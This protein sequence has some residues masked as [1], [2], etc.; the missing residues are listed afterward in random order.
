MLQT[1]NV[2]TQKRTELVDITAEVAEAVERTDVQSGLCHLFLPHTTAALVINENADP[3]VAIDITESLDR[4][5]PWDFDYRHQEGN[6]AAHIK[7][8]LLGNSLT[9]F[10]ED[11]KLLLGKWQGVFLCEFDGGRARKVVVKVVEG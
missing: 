9:V 2:R 10:V 4:L 3:S 7:S 5:I 8:S 1:I 6:A 11:G